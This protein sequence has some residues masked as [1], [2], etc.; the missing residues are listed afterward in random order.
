MCSAACLAINRSGSGG[1]SGQSEH[2]DRIS[3]CASPFAQRTLRIADF[4]LL[5]IGTGACS[6][7][8]TSTASVLLNVVPCGYAA[9]RACIILGVGS[10]PLDVPHWTARQLVWSEAIRIS[11]GTRVRVSLAEGSRVVARS[12]EDR[13]Q[14]GPRQRGGSPAAAPAGHSEVVGHS[15]GEERGTR[16]CAHRPLGVGARKSHA[17]TSK[18]VQVGRVHM[19]VA[20]RAD[21]ATRRKT[22]H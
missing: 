21:P 4:I 22:Y 3:M 6:T 1:S 9:T 13:K 16:G 10:T 17:G 11:V 7:P 20:K 19:R 12:L 14:G 18:R 8:R 5:P 2:H 15:T